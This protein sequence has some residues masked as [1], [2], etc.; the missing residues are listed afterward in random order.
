GT[1][2][3]GE[4][5]SGQSD[6]RVQKRS[7]IDKN[8]LPTLDNYALD[9]HRTPGGSIPRE[10]DP[11]SSLLRKPPRRGIDGSSAWRLLRHRRSPPPPAANTTR[12]GVTHGGQAGQVGLPLI[13][14]YFKIPSHFEY[15]EDRPLHALNVVGAN[16]FAPFLA[17]LTS[18]LHDQS[19]FEA[20][21]WPLYRV[22]TGKKLESRETPC[23]AR[24][25]QATARRSSAAE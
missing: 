18:T 15:R 20:V 17:A 12:S 8:S 10:R 13:R 21:E 4:L 24:P 11:F 16:V 22:G 6:G 5:S 9:L 1:S 3:L 25:G 14:R 7:R 19:C 23:Q 2:R